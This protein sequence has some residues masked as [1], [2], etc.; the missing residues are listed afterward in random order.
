MPQDM[1]ASRAAHA[2]ANV[3]GD[4]TLSLDKAS[5]DNEARIGKYVDGFM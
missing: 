3:R 5:E 4:L 1:G 2:M